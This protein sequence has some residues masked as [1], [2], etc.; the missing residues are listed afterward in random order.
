M[1]LQKFKYYEPQ[2]LGEAFSL[3]DLYRDNAAILAG[4][5]DLVPL[6]KKRAVQPK[7]IINI[8]RIRDLEF[9]KGGEALEIGPLTN[10]GAIEKSAILQERCPLL[11]NVAG[12]I[13]YV[14]VRNIGTIG[15]NICNASPAADFAPALMVLD[16]AVEIASINGKK[17]VSIKDFFVGPGKTILGKNEM[18]TSLHLP[19]F[20]VGS[21]YAFKKVTSRTSKGLAVAS[22]AITSSIDNNT[23]IVRAASIAVGSMGPTPLRCTKTE[24]VLFGEKVNQRILDSASE[25]I[26]KETKP[27]SDI[28]GTKQYRTQLIKSI[29][30]EAL[31]DTYRRYLN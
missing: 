2:Q 19:V 10:I 27:I 8:K 30:R 4:G 15:G 12:R 13:A 22:V 25:E 21:V 6:M 5:T 20:S 28:R 26:A 29:T 17:S 31:M 7:C 24:K 18:V 23:G 16:A 9:I 11:C 1:K 3:L 14:Q